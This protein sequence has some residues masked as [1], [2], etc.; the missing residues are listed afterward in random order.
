MF[1]TILF[2]YAALSVLYLCA[3]AGSSEFKRF[4]FYSEA[5]WLSLFVSIVGANLLLANPLLLVTAFFVLVFTACEA[6]TLAAVLLVSY[7]SAPAESYLG[8]RS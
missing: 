7:E 8:E 4:F 3:F 1:Q 2:W 5:V 6:V